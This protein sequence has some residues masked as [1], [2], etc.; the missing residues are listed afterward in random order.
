VIGNLVTTENIFGLGWRAAFIVAGAPGVLLAG[1]ILMLMA[2]PERTTEADNEVQENNGK[3]KDVTKTNELYS[4]KK[5]TK[6]DVET[7]IALRRRLKMFLH[8][9]VLLLYFASAVRMGAGLSFA[10]NNQVSHF[11]YYFKIRSKCTW[12]GNW[13]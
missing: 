7:E 13:F 5:E 1:L 9:F 3:T 4:E 8:P 10:Y 2:E 12:H 6:F 11:I